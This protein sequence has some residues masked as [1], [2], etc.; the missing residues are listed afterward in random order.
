MAE[1]DYRV[2]VIVRERRARFR[3]GVVTGIG[4]RHRVPLGQ[5]VIRE[6]EHTVLAAVADVEQPAVPV[7]RQR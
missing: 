3:G 1:I 4:V 7:F 2:E 5:A 6:I